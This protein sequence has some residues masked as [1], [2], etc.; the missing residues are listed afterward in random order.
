MNKS[1]VLAVLVPVLFLGTAHAGKSTSVKGYT[2]KDGTYVAPYKK[3]SPDST[4]LNNYGT[5]GNY[6][7]YTGKEGTVDPYRPTPANP[8]GSPYNSK[9]TK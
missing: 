7:P 1:L 3:S 2:K 9:H 4:K 5:K 8:S 6:N